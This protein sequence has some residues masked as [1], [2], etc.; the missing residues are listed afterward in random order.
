MAFSSR[1]KKKNQDKHNSFQGVLENWFAG[2]DEGITAYIHEMSRKQINIPKVLEFS[3]LKT[4][5][6]VETRSALKHQR[7]KQLL[8]MTGN[9]Y[10]DLVKVF[11]TNLT[12]DWKSLVSYVKR[13]KMKVTNEVWNSVTGIKYAGLKVGKGNTIGI[14]EFNKIQYY[15]SCVRDPSLSVNRFHAGNLNLTPR[16]IAYIIAWKLIPR[17]MNHAVLHEEDLILLYCIMNL[18]KVNWVYI[19]MEHML[20]SKRLTDYRFPYAILVSKLIDYF[21]VDTSNERNETVKVVSE[22]DNA[23]LIKMGFH[24][25]EGCLVFHKSGT[26]REER[27]ASNLNNEEGDDVVPMEDDIVQAAEQSCY[28]VHHSHRE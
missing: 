5:N 1:Q 19:I 17:G 8:K 9:V 12:L 18:I 20:K 4:E 14:Q 25:V 27:G 11:Y 22:I 7:L 10:H 28:E 3:W 16:L 2:D 23:T 15:R 6:L 13:I 21:G 24:K 26:H